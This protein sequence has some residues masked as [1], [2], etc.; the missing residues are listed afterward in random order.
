MGNL[1]YLLAALGL[2]ALGTLFLVLR[3]R[4]PSG[5]AHNIRNF[6]DQL[7]SLAPERRR[8]VRPSQVQLPEADAAPPTYRSVKLVAAEPEMIAEG[9]NPGESAQVGDNGGEAVQVGD[10][11]G[12]G[13]QPPSDGPDHHI[14]STVTELGTL[15]PRNDRRGATDSIAGQ[16]GTPRQ[17]FTRR[18]A[19][20]D[21]TVLS[22]ERAEGADDADATLPV[23][24]PGSVDT[25][26]PPGDG[27]G[28]ASGARGFDTAQPVHQA[29]DVLDPRSFDVPTLVVP[30]PTS[31]MDRARL[32][33][34]SDPSPVDPADLP[35]IEDLLD[36]E[37]GTGPL[38]LPPY[39]NAN[40]SG[41]RA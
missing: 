26:D 17:L 36:R 37:L 12:E 7:D 34:L 4:T 10:N 19:A 2:A 39:R 5:M 3:A 31:E 6:A 13:A 21:H 28:G 11:R 29:G 38:V 30:D 14:G 9:D 33:A 35:P 41:G 15:S 25:V 22:H 1:V 24:E 18:P 20:A 27:A 32:A 16:P 40:R 8:V 23:M